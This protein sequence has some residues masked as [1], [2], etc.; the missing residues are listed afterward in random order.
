MKL[1]SLLTAIALSATFSTVKAADDQKPK[2][3]VLETCVISGEKLGE[4]G[5]PYIFVYQGQEIKL[6]C[7]DCKKKWDK[8]PAAALKKYEAAAQAHGHSH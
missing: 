7:K 3:Y 1:T 4:M 6:C 8:D 2:P 5:K